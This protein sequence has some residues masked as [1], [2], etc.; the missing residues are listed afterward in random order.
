[1]PP[2]WRWVGTE[3]RARVGQEGR[4]AR[5]GGCSRGTVHRS[6]H[7][8]NRNLSPHPTLPPTYLGVGT[9][10]CRRCPRM[11]RV[12]RT[13]PAALPAALPHVAQTAVGAGP[14]CLG[15]RR[16]RPQRRWG[17]Q[18]RAIGYLQVHTRTHGKRTVDAT[19]SN[20]KQLDP[21]CR[22]SGGQVTGGRGKGA[23]GCRTEVDTA[24]SL[25]DCRAS[26][27]FCAALLASTRSGIVSGLL[28]QGG[29]AGSA[30]TTN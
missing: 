11:E 23:R 21:R 24:C 27:D 10:C 15:R 28:Q 5:G 26:S 2:A 30:A 22:S 7:P 18:P 1:M 16:R 6:I 17:Q 13:A 19:L 4:R 14:G 29:Q 12:D 9:G 8:L 3:G 20:F 25:P